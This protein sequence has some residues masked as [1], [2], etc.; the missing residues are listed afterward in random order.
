VVVIHCNAGKGRTGTAISCL[1]LYSGYVESMDDANKFYGR[2]RF[3]SGIGVSQPCQLRY[4]YYFEA[5][6]RQSIKIPV[7]KK[8]KAIV[9][10]TVPR[11]AY[12]GCKPYY[13]LA[14]G[15]ERKLIACNKSDDNLL[16]YYA[17]KD[18]AMHF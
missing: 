11:I 2:Q 18:S 15:Q 13:E 5:V 8:L 12:E 6:L 10:N 9:F 3:S 14:V 17:Y 1:L 4:I 16:Q 7:V